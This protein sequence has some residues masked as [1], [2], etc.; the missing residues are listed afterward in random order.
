M[1]HVH[2]PRRDWEA[3]F[4]RRINDDASTTD[5]L[6]T[7]VPL[8]S[9][10]PRRK[11]LSFRSPPLSAHTRRP[12]ASVVLGGGGA[13][14]RPTV[15][16]TRSHASPPPDLFLSP[17]S[18]VSSLHAAT[19]PSSADARE[20]FRYENI[21]RT[22]DRAELQVVIRTLRR[23]GDN[24]TLLRVAQRRLATLQPQPP[25]GQQQQ[26][27]RPLFASI[28]EDVEEDLGD[29]QIG[30][31]C[32]PVIP[33][34]QQPSPS[35]LVYSLEEERD[36][37]VPPEMAAS[38]SSQKKMRALENSLQAL[39]QTHQKEKQDLQRQ[40]EQ[41]QGA[42]NK[43]AAQSHELTQSLT[44]SQATTESLRR[45][46]QDMQEDQRRLQLQLETERS[47]RA[48]KHE[49]ADQQAT[50]LRLEI[51]TLER[52]M[53]DVQK[54]G[55]KTA[56]LHQVLQCARKNFANLQ[57]ERNALIHRILETLGRDTRGVPQMSVEG[58]SAAVQ[59]ICGQSKASKTAIQAMQEAL[60]TSEKER[61]KM[62]ESQRQTETRLQ[63]VLRNEQKLEEANRQLTQQI[64]QLTQELEE[65]RATADRLLQQAREQHQ[66]EWLK[67]E[68][69]FKTTIRKLQKQIHGEQALVPLQVY[70]AAV[71][72]AER[73]E[74]KVQQLD[75]K[76]VPAKGTTLVPRPSASLRIGNKVLTPILRN[77]QSSLAR[78]PKKPQLPTPK[79]LSLPTV[80]TIPKTKQNDENV[81]RLKSL[82]PPPPRRVGNKGAFKSILRN[83]SKA[84]PSLTPPQESKV[85]KVS[86]NKSLT[87]NASTPD[88]EQ[89][90]KLRVSVVVP[91]SDQAPVRHSFA[92][93]QGKSPSKN[94]M[95]I[96]RQNGG[97]RGMQ[98]KLRQVR[99]PTPVR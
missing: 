7:A 44:T 38:A 14:G 74:H 22:H 46:L 4:G 91:S 50:A 36:A 59:E 35:S 45:T 19:T 56:Q 30:G 73:L 89:P 77:R 76:P 1:S 6:S 83:G 26:H 87:S 96:I 63:A 11:A 21:V 8:F 49:E 5:S 67:R 12:V 75:S 62:S 57:S 13:T 69:M 90:G 37:L 58:R 2:G 61:R 40:H 54:A 24:P 82:V 41:I 60:Q 33:S 79:V 99:S 43:I 97:L 53:E 17:L 88:K 80:Q 51:G 86:G 66:R 81:F 42:R 20:R 28:Q 92:F 84:V 29:A 27:A 15:T 52:K 68:N 72:R 70:R 39:E 64:R 78:Q 16:T 23:L 31:F 3:Y 32:P 55:G 71:E 34:P 93:S 25:G 94:R 18:H 98:E 9:P 85:L 48:T 65:S 95:E 10:V 47:A